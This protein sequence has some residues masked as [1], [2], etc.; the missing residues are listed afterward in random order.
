MHPAPPS[1]RRDVLRGLAALAGGTL[2]GASPAH[3]VVAP[4]KKARDVAAARGILFGSAFDQHIYTSPSYAKLLCDE[5][6]IL[7]PDY[8]LKFDALRRTG[9][10]TID[11]SVADRLFDFAASCNLKMR[12]HTLIW[13][14]FMPDWTRRMSARE[15]ERLL[16]RHIDEVAGRYSGRVHSWDVVNEPIWIESGHKGGLRGGPWYNAMGSSYIARSFRRAKQ[17]DPHA[18]LVLNESYLEHKW[19]DSPFAKNR[20]RKP[21][22]PWPKFRDYF[23]DLVRHLGDENVPL[24]AIGMESHMAPKFRDEYDRDSLLEFMHT[25]K[26]MGLDI[27]ITELDVD[28]STFPDDFAKRDKGVADYYHMYLKDVLSVDAVKLL[29]TWELSDRHTSVAENIMAG[30]I[31]DVRM[32]RILPFDFDMRPKPAYNAIVSALMDK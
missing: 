27:Y 3:S 25:I 18:K 24:D 31:S 29:V 5:C 26:A 32:P 12:G 16:D 1:N 21:D 28:D 8:S 11:F 2:L 30:R 10:D 15:M 20:S 23:L 19:Y 17:A 22:S 6:A 13:N 4:A 9:P 14:D 7:T